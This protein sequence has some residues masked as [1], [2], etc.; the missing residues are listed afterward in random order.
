MTSE[1]WVAD[2]PVNYGVF[3]LG[4]DKGG[5]IP[6]GEE[7]A[8]FV[9]RAGYEGIDLGPS[10]FLG[11]GS[12]LQDRLRR[13]G[14]AL[15]GGWL[16]YPFSDAEAF[17][18]AVVTLDDMIANFLE[19][20]QADPDR[21]PRPT[22]ACSG[23]PLRQAHPGGAE[24]GIGLTDEQWA[25]FAENVQHVVD[26]FRDAGLEPTFH[27]HVCTYVET[28]AEIEQLLARTDVGLCLD[29]GHL[30]LGGGDP[31]SALQRWG[32]RINHVHLKDADRSALDA[33]VRGRGD[34][35]AAWAGNVFVPMGTGD[36]Q[37]EEFM[38]ALLASGYRGWALVE[39]DYIPAPDDPADTA[40]RAQKANREA[41]R[42]WLP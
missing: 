22:L 35:R 1:I 3:E 2:A 24:P 36:L 11:R 5:T 29:T 27:H 41:L 4:G 10:G 30:L 33:V 15:A 18:A 34:M 38:S 19:G 25:V 40:F 8:A 32:D 42:R 17:A 20:A 39:Q 16:D 7:C 23:S 12:D 9:A 13:H 31:L 26:R 37:V 6:D 28:P 14:L 21:P